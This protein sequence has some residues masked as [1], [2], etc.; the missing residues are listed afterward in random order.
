[1]E[2]AMVRAHATLLTFAIP[3]ITPA[4]VALLLPHLLAV[5]VLIAASDALICQLKVAKQSNLFL[6]E[7]A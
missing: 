6:I 4:A 2:V 3:A 7:T 5:L 1:M